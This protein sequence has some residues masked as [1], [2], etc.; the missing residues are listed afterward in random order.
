M[1]KKRILCTGGCGFVGHHVIEHLL[2]ST[3]YDIVVLDKLSYSSEGLDRLRDI[4]AFDEKR[5]LILTADLSKPIP[6]G[7]RQEIGKL[8]YIYHIAAESHV[9]RSLEDAI[10]FVV[11]NVLGTTYLLEYVKHY[12]KNLKKYIGFNTDECFGPAPEGVYSKETDKFLPSNPYSGAKGGQW[13][14][15]YSFAHSFKIPIILTHTMNIIGERQHPEKFIPMTI[16]K[17]MRGEKVILHGV[18]DKLSSRKWIHARNVA[19]ALLF[20]LDKGVP[21]ESY[22]IAGEEKDVLEIANM[23]SQ[24]VNGRV[25]EKDEYEIHDVHSQRPG[26]DLRYSL[27]GEK[28]EKLGWKSPVDLEE[29]LTKVIEWTMKNPKWI[30]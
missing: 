2:K 28:M 11:S 14:M 16:R 8:D 24:V 19:D 1:S 20:L 12:Q 5:V 21:E 7:L 13:C 30:G 6:E 22:N 15:E 9:E 17:L 10:P 18:K 29:S 23:I 25:M 3:D 4:E 27:S 26:H